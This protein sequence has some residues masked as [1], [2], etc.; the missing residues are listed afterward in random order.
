VK[1]WRSLTGAEVYSGKH[2]LNSGKCIEHNQDIIGTTANGHS[3]EEREQ[4]AQ[5][6]NGVSRSINFGRMFLA[7]I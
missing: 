7:L 2:P 5:G 1:H 3:E 6:L 4:S